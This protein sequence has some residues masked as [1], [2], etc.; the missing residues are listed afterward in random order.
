[1][2]LFHLPFRHMHVCLRL[3]YTFDNVISR[4]LNKKNTLHMDPTYSKHLQ[5]FP[6]KEIAI[7]CI[8]WAFCEPN[9]TVFYFGKESLTAAE[10]AQMF[11]SINQ[12][13]HRRMDI[14]TKI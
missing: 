12:V 9:F 7:S 2:V 4:V 10:R 14:V 13:K 8:I 3:I 5:V 6:Y 11:D 1:M